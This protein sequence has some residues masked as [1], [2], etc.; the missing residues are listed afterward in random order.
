MNSIQ[1]NPY[2]HSTDS[3][4]V[5]EFNSIQSLYS[6]NPILKFTQFNTCIW[7]QF[8]AYTFIQSNTR[9]LSIQYLYRFNPILAHFP[10]NPMPKF[11]QS[12][13]GASA[14]EASLSVKP[15]GSG[16]AAILVAGKIKI[17]MTKRFFG[18][19]C[20]FNFEADL[21]KIWKLRAT[22]MQYSDI[23]KDLSKFLL[24]LLTKI[25][26]NAAVS[27][28]IDPISN[29]LVALQEHVITLFARLSSICQPLWLDLLA[30]HHFTQLSC[31][32]E[33]YRGIGSSPPR[34]GGTPYSEEGGD[35]GP[36]F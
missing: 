24:T 13:W 32:N 1:S 28:K 8:N 29:I 21:C 35:A 3:I 18:A 14:A 17:N 6:F 36:I 19:S 23:E 22:L 31:W 16:P 5:Y 2:I 11:I 25:G 4:H 12:S 9:I 7:I 26:S 34:G 27:F 15:S 20:C 30:D 10:F 33:D